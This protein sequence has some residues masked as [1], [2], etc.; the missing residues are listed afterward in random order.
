MLLFGIVMLS[1]GTINTFLVAKFSLTQIAVGSLAALLP[2]GI[3][4][5]SLVFGPIVDRYGYK[6][7]LTVSSFLIFAGLEAIAYAS[8]LPVVQLSFFLIGFGGGVINGGTNALV[9]DISSDGRGARLSLLGVFFGVGALGMPAVTGALLK[10]YSY[11]TIVAGVGVVVIVPILFFLLSSFPA[12]K[13]AQGFPLKKAL[14]LLRDATLIFMGLILFFESG[15]EGMAN[16][17]TTTYLQK[18]INASTEDALFALTLLLASLTA[19]RLVLGGVLKRFP[20]SRVLY[21]S[22]AIAFAGGVVLLQS[23]TFASALVAFVLLGVGF[24]GTFPIVFSFV[25]ERYSALTGTAF[26]VV[27]VIALLGNTLLNYCVGL[28]S[29]SAGIQQF[30]LVMLA[31]IATMAVLVWVVVKRSAGAPSQSHTAPQP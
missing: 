17:W 27:L 26:S 25:G 29:E 22:V 11:E 19:A 8:T 21:A 13:Q 5:G 30:P 15:L 2:F 20:P 6:T 16:A 7:P 12:P 9:A 23:R 24:A 10:L 31:S 28:I 3:L 18:Q 1:L 14:G 4:A